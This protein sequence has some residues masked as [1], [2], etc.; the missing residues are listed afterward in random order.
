[1]KKM[2]SLYMPIYP[3]QLFIFSNEDEYKKYF[4][5]K[6]WK[7]Y[8]IPYFPEPTG[9]FTFQMD[10]AEYGIQIFVAIGDFSAFKNKEFRQRRIENTIVHECVHVK[11]YIMKAICERKPAAEQEAYLVAYIVEQLTQ[12]Y[13]R[14]VS[15]NE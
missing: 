15:E 2:R 11:Q 10:T 4:S 3:V 13:N 7:Q 12:E 14:S 5:S 6:F 9:A 1:M 8:S